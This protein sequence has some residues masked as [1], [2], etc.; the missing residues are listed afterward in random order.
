MGFCNILKG[1]CGMFRNPEAHQP[2]IYWNIEEQDALEILGYHIVIE[3]W[4]ML[5][6]KMTCKISPIRI[7]RIPHPKDGKRRAILRW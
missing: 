1:L 4:I 5:R 6:K 7:I 3:D 2:K